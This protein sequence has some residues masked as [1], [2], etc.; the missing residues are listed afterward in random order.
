MYSF[1]CPVKPGQTVYVITDC[2]QIAET[3]VYSIEFTDETSDGY[4]W[5]GYLSD[6]GWDVD[7]SSWL[8]WV[9][10]TRD[11]AEIALKKRLEEEQT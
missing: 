5:C 3:T 8:Y 4:S 7:N 6:Y 2:A 9:F 10:Q 1:E 11:E